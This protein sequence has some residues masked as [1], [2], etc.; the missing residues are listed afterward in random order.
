M[1]NGAGIDPSYSQLGY[2][3]NGTG[4]CS[5]GVLNQAACWPD[6]FLPS[7]FS[8]PGTGVAIFEQHVRSYETY[9]VPD[10]SG[11]PFWNCRTINDEVWSRAL[12]C[13]PPTPACAQWKRLKCYAY[14][15]GF[16]ETNCNC[17]AESPIAID[18]DGDGFSFTD[19]AG[20]VYFDLR[21]SGTAQH[22]S[23]TAVGSDDSWLVLDRNGNGA[24]DSGREMFGNFTR[25]PEPPTGE[26][27]NGFLALAEYDKPENG[28]NGNGKINAADSIFSSLRLWQDINHN[29]ISEGSELHTFQQVGLTSID[30]AYH[31]SRQT[32]QYGN[33]FRYRAKVRDQ[34]NIGKWAWDMILLSTP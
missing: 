11:R 5:T 30:L 7:A 3:T 12:T 4:Q 23:W 22:L 28:G 29:A 26:E 13:P 6:F 17:L 21:A 14:G 15:E 8:P 18:V 34:T 20:G 33:Q 10:A 32:D 1:A 2:E 24:I 25:Q 31:K 16:D 9:S 19:L 27:M